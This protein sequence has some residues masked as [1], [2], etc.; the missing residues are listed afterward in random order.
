MSKIIPSPLLGAEQAAVLRVA[1]AE[2]GTV[3]DPPGSNAGPVLDYG[4]KAGQPWCCW[5][6][7]WCFRRA[8]GRWPADMASQTGGTGTLLTMARKQKLAYRVP[9]PGDI[10]YKP[11][12]AASGR[13]LG[14]HVGIVLA[15]S[16]D[17][18]Q[19]WTIEGNRGDAVRIQARET[20]EWRWF[21]RGPYQTAQVAELWLGW[22]GQVAGRTEG[23]A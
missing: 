17:G 6:V 19:V 13:R 14:G 18:R 9:E 16:R 10:A 23:E 22:G 8:T 3:E 5:F 1:L 4:G 20:A 7:T 12:L 2:V 11:R 15:V 21:I